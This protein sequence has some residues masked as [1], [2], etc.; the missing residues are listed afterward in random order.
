MT[1]DRPVYNF[2]LVNHNVYWPIIGLFYCMTSFFIGHFTLFSC[3][4][5]DFHYLYY[6]LKRCPPYHVRNYLVIN[7]WGMIISVIWGKYNIGCRLYV[8]IRILWKGKNCRQF[9]SLTWKSFI[10]QFVYPV[11]GEGVDGRHRYYMTLRVSHKNI[12]LDASNNSSNNN[13][14]SSKTLYQYQI[15]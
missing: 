14:I 10:D 11:G 4:L 13:N 6:L 3:F 8:D 9:S 1:N 12:A 2:P 15:T 5:F 7:S